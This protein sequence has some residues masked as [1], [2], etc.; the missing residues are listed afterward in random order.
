MIKVILFAVIGL[1]IGLGGGSAVSV[2]QARKA[3]AADAARTAKIVADSLA[4]AEE[5]G[6]T[7]VARTEARADSAGGDSTAAEGA[8]DGRDS[9]KAT[10]AHEGGAKEVASAHGADT[11]AGAH[12]PAPVAAPKP[13]KLYSRAVRTV[14]ANGVPDHAPLAATRPSLPPKPMPDPSV[15]PGAAK[16]AKIFA[17]MPA[18]DAAKV[19]EQLDDSDVQSVIST[20]REKQ[21]AAVI[22]NLPP[23]RAAR[24][25]KAVLRSVPPVKP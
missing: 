11:A 16:L 2:M 4:K 3:H 18:K 8:H 12:A 9:A 25:T 10:V 17:A 19:L 14:E 22:Q 23:E 6:G 21:A 7:H 13:P 5:E 1:V 20:L 24:I 15:Q